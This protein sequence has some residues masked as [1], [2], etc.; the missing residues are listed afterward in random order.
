MSAPPFQ[1]HDPFAAGDPTPD[2]AR[3]RLAL[4]LMAA[5]Y[6][7]RGETRAAF[8]S[9]DLVAIAW[10]DREDRLE[11]AV[12][13]LEEMIDFWTDYLKSVFGPEQL[14]DWLKGLNDDDD[15]T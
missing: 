9:D 1:T 10:T 4:R 13:D 5:M 6:A 14:A 12:T 11:L 2:N 15:S 3:H 7:D 8:I